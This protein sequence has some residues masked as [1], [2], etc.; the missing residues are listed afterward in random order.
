MRGS[1]DSSSHINLV[2]DRRSA[3]ERIISLVLHVYAIIIIISMWCLD[4]CVMPF[5]N[6]AT[7]LTRYPHLHTVA[8]SPVWLAS[9]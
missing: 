1:S 3:I 5:Q 6:K 2:R 8:K 9:K 4:V 7:L